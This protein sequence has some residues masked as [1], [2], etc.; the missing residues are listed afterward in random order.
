[1]ES[2]ILEAIQREE[3]MTKHWDCKLMFKEEEDGLEIYLI[4]YVNLSKQKKTRFPTTRPFQI[5]VYP[6][7]LIDSIALETGRKSRR[8]STNLE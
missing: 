6:N 3:V 7:F 1:M 2:L 4:D 8:V 5:S